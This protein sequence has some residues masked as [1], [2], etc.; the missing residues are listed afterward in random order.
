VTST[1]DVGESGALV[2]RSGLMTSASIAIAPCSGFELQHG[3]CKLDY[4]MSMDDP[5]MLDSRAMYAR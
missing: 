2:A 3:E 4:S 1:D 5:A